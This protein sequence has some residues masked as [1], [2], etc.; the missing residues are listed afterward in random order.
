MFFVQ[1]GAEHVP[2]SLSLPGGAD[3]MYW[4]PFV[5]LVVE[6]TIGWILL[7]TGMSRQAFESNEI[8][9]AYSSG[10]AKHQTPAWPL[11]PEPPIRTDWAWILD[12]DPL[13]TALE[14]VGLQVSDITL[15]AVSHLH[16]DHS[17]G[18]PTLAEHGVP[19]AI[20][21]RELEFVRSGVS[22]AAGFYQP[23]WES[24]QV[25][26]IEIDG[27][28]ELAPGVLALATPGHTPGH[29]SFQVTL[30]ETGVWLFAGDAADLGQNFLDATP[31]TTATGTAADEIAAE[32]SLTRLLD[33][34]RER[35]ARL[36]PGHDQLIF[37]AVR[38]PTGG[39]K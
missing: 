4:E 30:P 12:G 9:A 27:D 31:C 10:D 13:E 15:A 19:I 29:M 22:A 34:A 16:V 26:W 2:K 39:H 6:T 20:Q 38:P 23:D 11:A 28:A 17:G 7:D 18:I 5:G 14:A 8:A 25:M 3:N 36:I 35:D 21:S 24:E 37:N 1:F 32:A 33:I